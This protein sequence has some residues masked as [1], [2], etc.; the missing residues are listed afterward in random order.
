MTDTDAR[1]APLIAIDSEQI[2]RLLAPVLQGARIVEVERVTGGLINT[3]CRV[4]T[5]NGV[6]C[7]RIFAQ[8]LRSWAKE[9][10]MLARVAASLP[11]PE[12]VLAGV[13]ET[14][15][16]HPYLVYH[17]IE[18]ITLNECRRQTPPA[19]LLSLAEPLGQLL[20][21][22]ASVSAIDWLDDA[23]AELASVA[24]ALATSD[25]CLRRGLARERLG[26]TLA[27]ALWQ[28]LQDHAPQLLVLDGKGLV[29]GDLGGRN[30]LVTP[31]DDGT[32]RIN[33]LIDWENAFSGSLLWDL[34]SL[35]RYA[36]RYAKPFRERFAQGYVDAGGSL[37]ED[38]YHN[39]RWLD[40]T[41]QVH[42]LNEEKG[43][44]IVF[45]ECRELLEKLLADCE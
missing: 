14:D 44:P 26:A 30:I 2:Q 38:W 45:A 19:V 1:I 35:F 21:R 42:T 25:N 12:A 40:A 6:F 9:R 33:G 29:H 37:P 22:V 11:V 36:R 8:G 32:W 27:E 4:T 31:A 20:A 18:G 15:W 41:R 17:W 7:L 34:G 10:S 28:R 5:T 39:A 24:A 43:L 13:G 3:I 23:P 16:Q